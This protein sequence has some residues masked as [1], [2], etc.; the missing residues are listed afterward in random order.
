L[1]FKLKN[2]GSLLLK[3]DRQ[4]IGKDKYKQILKKTENQK[5]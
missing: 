5:L 4:R 2:L 3:G 1:E